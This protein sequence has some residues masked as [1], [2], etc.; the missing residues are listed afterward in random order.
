L[1][2]TIEIPN[3]LRA[4][5]LALAAKRGIRGYSEIIQEAVQAYL[6]REEEREAALSEVLALP[7]CLTQEDSRKAHLQIKEMWNRWM[8]S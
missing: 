2:T 4:R 8:S 5:L 1:R 7:G 6:D 3:D